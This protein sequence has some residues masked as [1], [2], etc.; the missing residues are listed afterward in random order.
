MED[1]TLEEKK[2]NVE[3]HEKLIGKELTCMVRN[4]L[5]RG[6]DM[7]LHV[8]LL[9]LVGCYADPPYNS[10]LLFVVEKDMIDI[11]F[12]VRFKSY[13]QEKKLHASIRVL[14]KITVTFNYIREYDEVVNQDY[15]Q[16][17][18]FT[19]DNSK[20]GKY[21]YE[22]RG[23]ND[24]E[25]VDEQQFAK[26][27]KTKAFTLFKN[28]CFRSVVQTLKLNNNIQDYIVDKYNFLSR[29]HYLKKVKKAVT[30]LASNRRSG[31]YLNSI[32]R[33]IIRI[34]INYL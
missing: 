25:I 11:S 24:T 10:M 5:F 9:D 4:K 6:Y 3:E 27:S 13:R 18:T 7:V 30:L 29:T 8:R 16:K 33:D 20:K 26:F 21:E 34:I 19:I 1:L 31:D 32:P 15:I 2:D 17:I 22:Y 28:S 23:I 14:S 12:S